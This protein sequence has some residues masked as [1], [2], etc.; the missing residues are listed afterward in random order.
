MKMLNSAHI[1][2]NEEKTDP[3]SDNKRMSRFLYK[4]TTQ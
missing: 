1:N 3:S 2:S 4:N